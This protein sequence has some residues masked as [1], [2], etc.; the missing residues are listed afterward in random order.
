[1]D[2]KKQVE[3][4]KSWSSN[5]SVAVK[6][7]QQMRSEIQR[8]SQQVD[9]RVLPVS[10]N[11]T[12]VTEQKASGSHWLSMP[13]YTHSEGYKM[14]LVVHP[15]GKKSGTG[16]HVSVAVYLMSGKYDNQLDWPLNITLRVKLLN[17]LSEDSHHISNTYEL[18]TSSCEDGIV[19][20]VW[21]DTMAKNGM[22]RARFA[23]HS[24]VFESTNSYSFVKHNSLHFH[25]DKVDD[26]RSW[27][28]R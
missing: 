8:L 1:M 9:F 22:L 12:H 28:W 21:Y 3:A 10:L 23:L 4:I 13:F 2:I 5:S 11:L 14:R 15:D 25:V 7:I 24:M 26:S 27:F 18:S 19:E 17:Q 16:S 6:D 20:R